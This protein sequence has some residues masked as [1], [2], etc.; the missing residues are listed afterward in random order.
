MSAAPPR[1]LFVHAHPDDEAIFTGVAMRRAADAGAH[2]VLACLTGG[3]VADE[4]ADPQQLRA[5]R[6]TELTAAAAILGAT[7]VHVG[8]WRDSGMPGSVHN[9]DPRAL[10]RADAVSAAGWLADVAR[11]EAVDTIVGYDANGIYA[12]GDHLAVHTL[13][14][15]AAR[16]TG[17]VPVAATMPAGAV[18]PGHLL[19]GAARG[20][21]ARRVGTPAA[22]I[23]VT[24]RATS[25]ELAAKVAAMR[26]HASQIPA[27][28]LTVD[29]ARVYGDEH[30]LL[31]A[32]G[33]H[34]GGTAAGLLAR[35]AVAACR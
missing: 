14:R 25:G 17:A 12:H 22:R 9:G 30:Y 35:S 24:V 5:Q 28:A 29:A 16:T 32:A 10:V 26:A 1:V 34:L 6:L 11:T 20:P 4:G 3:E 27:A 18:P 23:D 33:R 31:P 19:A 2:V 8:A 21:L 13:A 15:A 7:R